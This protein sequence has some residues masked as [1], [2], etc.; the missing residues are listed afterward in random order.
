MEL[1]IKVPSLGEGIEGGDV[2]TIYVSVGDIIELEQG[3]LELETGKAAVDIPAP[4]AG[5]VTEIRVNEGDKIKVGDVI[6]MMEG[7]T[8]AA[9]DPAETPAEA[10]AALSGEAVRPVRADRRARRRHAGFRS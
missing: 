10:A 8:E 7:G 9:T 1:E 6:I 4:E 3:L 5:K 2:Q